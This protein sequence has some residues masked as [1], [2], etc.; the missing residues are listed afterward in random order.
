MRAYRAVREAGALPDE[1][2]LFLLDHAIQWTPDGGGEGAEEDG[3]A[4]GDVLDRHTLASLG[5]CGA[6]DLAEMYVRGRPGYDRRRERGRQFFYGP[7]DAD[8]AERLREKGLI[9]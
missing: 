5:R 3:Q 8:L 6:D 4:A 1:A 7:P 9:D 2:A